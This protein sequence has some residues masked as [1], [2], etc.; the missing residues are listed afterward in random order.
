MVQYGKPK[1]LTILQDFSQNIWPGGAL[2]ECGVLL[3][4]LVRP[5]A[6]YILHCNCSLCQQTLLQPGIQRNV[7]SSAAAEDQLPSPGDQ[8]QDPELFPPEDWGTMSCVEVGCGPGLTGLA[9]AALGA[10]VVLTDK[11]QVVEQIAQPNVLN[12]ADV[13]KGRAA[14]CPLWWGEDTAPVLA[15]LEGLEGSS[16]AGASNATKKGSK[17]PGGNSNKNTASSG[18]P[19]VNL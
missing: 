10:K 2:W 17:K 18:T 11:P 3:G 6:V 14:A 9:A 19:K 12:N 13:H 7:N 4:K 15:A 5:S 8:L 16:A 1:T